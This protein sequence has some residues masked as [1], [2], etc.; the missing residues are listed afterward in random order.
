VRVVVA[1][2]GNALLQRDET[3]DADIQQ[4]HL[5]D[6]GTAVAALAAHNE[7]LICHGNGPQ[8]GLLS[9]ESESD[10]S[11][12]RPYPLDVLGAQTQGMIGYWLAQAIRNGGLQT[13]VVSVL[14]QTVVDPTDRAFQTPT[15]F[16]GR[17][18]TRAEA[19]GLAALHDWRVARDGARWRRVVASPEPAAV[20]ELEP[21]R[22]LVESGVTVICGGGGGAPVVQDHAG[23][24]RGVDAVVDKD[25]TSAWLAV[26]L[27]A[28]RLIILTDV[29]AV[30]AN[31]GRTDAQPLPFID[32]GEEESAGYPT[33]SMG[34]KV[35]ACRRFALATGRTATI[36]ALSDAASVF[37]GHAGTVIS[38]THH[39]HLPAQ[40][41]PPTRPAQVA[42]S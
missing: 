13:P 42:T 22:T 15:K 25:L 1:I 33:G 16:V 35:E 8:V 20:V 40:T 4:R 24:L 41:A 12:T 6:V 2:G 23:R 10:T 14:S 31:F 19:A 39:Q 7:L 38:R 18:Y 29:P 28:D 30:M 37:A 36:G 21:I 32:A 34:P 11:L 9:L 27:Q 3:P 26:A 5:R 17:T